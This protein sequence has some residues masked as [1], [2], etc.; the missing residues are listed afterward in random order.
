VSAAATANPLLL[1]LREVSLDLAGRRILSALSLELHRGEFLGI[2]GPNGGGKTSLLRVML[3][4]LPVSGGEVRWR[5]VND[6]L[7]RLGYVPQRSGIDPSCPF[8]TREVVRQGASG[9]LPLFGA[10]RRAV[11]QRADELLER[12]SL[13]DRADAPFNQLS[14]GQQRRALL[15]R[16]LLNQPEALLLDEPT[17]GVDTEG[18]Q[19][20][21]ALLRELSSHGIAIVLVSHDI[22][23]V[24]SHADR[25]ACVAGQ[26]HWHGAASALDEK[27]VQQ[28]YRCELDRYQLR[29]HRQHSHGPGC[30]H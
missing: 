26:L 28:T 6:T 12:V 22:P 20:F 8:S 11:Q 24:T 5:K 23:L 9:A 7:P 30:R 18:Q 25:V 21:C 16:A 14:G 4:L 17:A 13:T 1:T 19:Q 10:R 15:A 27:T 3:G 29:P 2:L